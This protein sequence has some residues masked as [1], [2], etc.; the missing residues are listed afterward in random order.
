MTS[1][2]KITRMAAVATI[3]ALG[4][5][6]AAAGSVAAG[7]VPMKTIKIF[8][9]SQERLYPVL[10]TPLTPA[11][12]WLQGIFR[13]TNLVRDTYAHTQL[14]RVYILPQGG[15]APG[16]SAVVRVPFYSDLVAKPRADKP[17]QYIDWWNGTRVYLYDDG[18]A[19]AKQLEKDKPVTPLTKSI[20]CEAKSTCGPLTVYTPKGKQVGLPVNDPDQLIEYTFA[21]VV[22]GEGTPFRVDLT[23][24]DYDISYVDQVYLPV[25][26]EPLNNKTVGFIGS[27]QD[28]RG[29]RDAL[30]RFLTAAPGWP[31]YVGTPP[32]PHPRIPGAYNVFI[33]G[34]D[35]TAPGQ[36]VEQMVETWR[37]CTKPGGGGGA[38]CGPY[39]EINAFFQ[40][41]YDK[42]TK[43][44]CKPRLPMTEKLLIQ[45]VYGWVP[46]N[47]NC[48]NAASANPLKD[49]P[50]FKTTIDTYTD[51]QYTPPGVFNPYVELIHGKNFLAMNAYAFSIDDAVGNMNEVGD[52]LVVTVG[53]K[54]GLDNGRPFDKDKVIHVNLGTPGKGLPKWSAFG[55][56][57]NK[58]DQDINPAFLSFALYTVDYPCR[59]VIEDS[60]QKDYTFVIRN[61]PPDPVVN[62]AASTQPAWCKAINVKKDE[63]GVWY[64]ETQPTVK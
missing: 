33:G 54:R 8:N 7:P 37:T 57:T 38:A 47:E 21:D 41:N 32:Y 53:G 52:G 2:G 6:A 44:T 42:Y 12:E 29:F 51:L 27:V 3:L 63:K 18:A 28:T 19:V 25:A 40:L 31:T 62:C 55:V 36:T 20:T 1:M 24:V 43:L 56:C 4:L 16:A 13:A 46:F 34:T 26:I 35:I 17:D 59:M 14:Y 23:H 22:T 61:A 9:N 30:D 15:I 10:E 49:T 39:K 64:I 48:V 5:G 50:G 58:T 60:N 11:D 45:H